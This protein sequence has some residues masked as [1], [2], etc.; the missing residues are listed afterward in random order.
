M[1]LNYRYNKVMESAQKNKHFS[2]LPSKP[3]SQ[4]EAKSSNDLRREALKKRIAELK[5]K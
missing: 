2:P 5:K 1:K 4:A 3:I